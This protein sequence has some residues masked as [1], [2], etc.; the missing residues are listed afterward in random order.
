MGKLFANCPSRINPLLQQIGNYTPDDLTSLYKAYKHKR[1]KHMRSALFWGITQ[2]RVVIFY[3]RFGTTYRSHL[4]GSRSP[5]CVLFLDFIM[6]VPHRTQ[7]HTVNQ[8]HT[9]QCHRTLPAHLTAPLRIRQGLHATCTSK[10]PYDVT[11]SLFNI[12]QLQKSY[13]CIVKWI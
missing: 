9:I 2:R 1:P 13:N 11:C 10:T 12:L 6:S 4:Q 3:R 5:G 8:T 7:W